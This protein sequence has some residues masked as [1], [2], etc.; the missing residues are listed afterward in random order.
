MLEKSLQTIIDRNDFT[1]AIAKHLLEVYRKNGCPLPPEGPKAEVKD[2][3][4]ASWRA[5]EE[6]VGDGWLDP[7]AISQEFNEGVDDIFECVG[8]YHAGN[9]VYFRACEQGSKEW[10]AYADEAGVSIGEWLG[11]SAWQEFVDANN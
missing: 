10:Q 8:L 3:D 5:S 9:G 1:S 4:L 11:L 2:E 7:Y 6:S